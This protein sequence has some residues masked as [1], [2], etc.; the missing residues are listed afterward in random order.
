[1]QECL[2]HL[3]ARMDHDHDLRS[4]IIV[5]ISAVVAA[6]PCTIRH[7]YGYGK[8]I[9]LD[10][11]DSRAYYHRLSFVFVALGSICTSIDIVNRI[12]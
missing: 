3:S 5:I 6:L 9:D 7:G 1:M 10:I 4:V 11:D 8:L 2:I 12:N